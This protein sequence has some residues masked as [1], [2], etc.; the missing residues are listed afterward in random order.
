LCKRLSPARVSTEP[1]SVARRS[2]STPPTSGAWAG[3]SLRWSPSSCSSA[4]Y[5]RRRHTQLHPAH[6][7]VRVDRDG[8]SRVSSGS[9]DA[10]RPGHV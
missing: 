7:L 1:A 9:T 2:A 10:A 6:G 5:L 4:S 8:A 3:W